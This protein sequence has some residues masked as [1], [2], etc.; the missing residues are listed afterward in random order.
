QVSSP[1]RKSRTSGPGRGGASAG[2]SSTTP[3]S[4]SVGWGGEAAGRSSWPSRASTKVLAVSTLLSLRGDDSG[5]GNGPS[6]P[7]RIVETG[8]YQVL[9]RWQARPGL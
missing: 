6:D 7:S 3:S 8:P 9:A 1:R 4:I 5:W 2:P